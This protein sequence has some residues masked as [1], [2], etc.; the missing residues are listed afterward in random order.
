[1]SVAVTNSPF[2]HVSSPGGGESMPTSSP[3]VTA[4]QAAFGPQQMK[5]IDLEKLKALDLTKYQT[6]KVPCHYYLL[7]IVPV[8]GWIAFAYFRHQ[9][10]SLHTKAQ[11]T[12]TLCPKPKNIDEK[13]QDLTL[14]ISISGRLAW[15]YQLERARYYLLSRDY[16]KAEEDLKAVQAHRGKPMKLGYDAS[17]LGLVYL[18]PINEHYSFSKA[19]ERQYN[20]EAEAWL[21]AS[22]FAA[23]KEYAKAYFTYNEIATH[24]YSTCKIRKLQVELVNAMRA[25]DLLDG[26]MGNILEAEKKL[27]N[28]KNMP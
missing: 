19:I 12:L 20:D 26:Q 13:I 27:E 7:L 22:L 15:Q 2:P 5:G 11:S 8:V 28:L 6:D 24:G 4:A 1:M 3:V 16:D 23:Q 10:K 21:Q 14:V 18:R 9:L 25:S 17:D